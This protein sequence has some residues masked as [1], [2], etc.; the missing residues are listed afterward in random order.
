MRALLAAGLLGHVHVQAR[1]KCRPSRGASK[2]VM[3]AWG[4]NPHHMVVEKTGYT[5]I[6]QQGSMAF[7]KEKDTFGFIDVP[8]HRYW[9]AQTQRS[10]QNFKIG[11]VRE[12]MPESLISAFG[13]L[14]K[15]AAL[16]NVRN[17]LH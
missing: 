12:R 2:L 8:A 3:G 9:G 4:G 10:L 16:V 17:V 15:A 7:R 14:K 13:V 1:A 5:T 11:G 6:G